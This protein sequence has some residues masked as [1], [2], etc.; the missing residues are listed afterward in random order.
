MAFDPSQ[1][2]TLEI[3]A[4]EAGVLLG[5]VEYAEESEAN[6]LFLVLI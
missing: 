6:L 1:F 5:T 3:L 4:C 2:P